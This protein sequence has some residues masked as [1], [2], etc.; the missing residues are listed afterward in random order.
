MEYRRLW[1]S[2]MT[3]INIKEAPYEISG[4]SVHWKRIISLASPERPPRNLEGMTLPIECP[5][6]P[7][8]SLG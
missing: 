2:R 7:P 3:G 6:H 1:M 4:P 5:E 8:R